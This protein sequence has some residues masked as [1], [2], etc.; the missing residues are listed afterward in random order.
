M[1]VHELVQLF[2]ETI[3]TQQLWQFATLGYHLP[4]THA[5]TP[6]ATFIGFENQPPNIDINLVPTNLEMEC[7]QLLK[8]LE[9]LCHIYQRP[10]NQ[11][12]SIPHFELVEPHAT[13]IV[14]R[15]ETTYQQGT[16]LVI[17]VFGQGE[18]SQVPHHRPVSRKNQGVGIITCSY[19]QQMG[20]LFNHCP[21]VNYML[22]LLVREEVMNVH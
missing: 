13:P 8:R 3:S 17:L 4:K 6:I 10:S 14:V 2:D 5:P 9:Q 11:L 18:R 12:I 20:L 19:C 15:Q 22:R 7:F 16:W 1:N 21:F